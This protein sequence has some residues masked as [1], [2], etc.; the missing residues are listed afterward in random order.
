MF[1]P[2]VSPSSHMLRSKEGY[3]FCV[4]SLRFGSGLYD[5]AGFLGGF[6]CGGVWVGILTLYLAGGPYIC[7]WGFFCGG[8]AVYLLLLLGVRSALTEPLLVC[9]S[10]IS[11]GTCGFPLCVMQLATLLGFHTSLTPVG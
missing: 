1:E 4:S 6:T 7:V 5:E 10:A 3:Q 11:W 9:C 8:G 2:H